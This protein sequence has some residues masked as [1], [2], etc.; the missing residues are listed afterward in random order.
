[1]DALLLAFC[2]SRYLTKMKRRNLSEETGL[3]EETIR[4]WYQNQRRVERKRADN[5]PRI[6]AIIA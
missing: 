2:Q 1:M 5:T 6:S 3:K 4:V